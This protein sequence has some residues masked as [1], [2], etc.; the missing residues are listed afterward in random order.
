MVHVSSSPKFRFVQAKRNL[1]RSYAYR[2]DKWRVCFGIA[3]KVTTSVHFKIHWLHIQSVPSFFPFWASW[4]K[5]ANHPDNIQSPDASLGILGKDS[6]TL[7]RREWLFSDLEWSEKLPS[8]I[9]IFIQTSRCFR[10]RILRLLRALRGIETIIPP[11]GVPHGVGGLLAG[12]CELC[13]P[14][15]VHPGEFTPTEAGLVL[16]FNQWGARVESAD[17]PLLERKSSSR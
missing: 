17:S 12:L 10:D 11:H 6:P 3:P 14:S 5:R 2:P 16:I 1:R 13:P 15:G 8:L 9:K 4:L 7:R